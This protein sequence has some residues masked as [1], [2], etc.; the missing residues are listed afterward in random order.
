MDKLQ[1]ISVATG[2]T[3]VEVADA[4]LRILCGCPAD[5]VKHLMKRGLILER[6]KGGVRY[7]SGPNAIL[8][9]DTMLQHGEFSNLAEFPVL[10]M[11]YKQGMLIP[12]HPNNAGQKPLLIGR[13]QQVNAQMQYIFRGNYGL[14]SKEEMIQAGLSE[15]QAEEQMR[16]KLRFA[17]GRISPS[18]QLLD[19]LAVEEQ[20]VEIRAGVFIE[21]LAENQYRI[22]Y[23]DQQIDVDLALPPEQ[24]YETPYPL[25]YQM[26]ER[27]YFAVLHSGEGDGWDV[28][29]PSM[30]SILMYQGRIYLIDAG[31]NL[32]EN[33]SALGIGV[34]EI[35]GIFHTH[36]HDD[37]FSGIT[38][39][40]R[41]GHRLKY[42]AVP[43][44]RST[45]AKK[46]AALLSI[47]EERFGDY[48]E[49]HDLQMGSWNCIEGLEVKP[50]F[51]PHPVET[52]IFEFRALWNDGYK[53]YA[54]FAD[55]VSLDLLGKMVEEDPTKPGVSQALYAQVKEDYLNPVDLKKLDIGGGMIHG[56]AE[57]FR[58]DRSGK[59]FLSHTAQSLTTAQKEIGS[60]APYGVVDV[61]IDSKTDYTRS[62]ARTYIKAY[63]PNVPDFEHETLLNGELLSFNPGSI[64]LKGDAAVDN[65]L[66]L[67]QGNVERLISSQDIHSSMDAGS[68]I[69]EMAVLKEMPAEATYR[70]TN[71]VQALRIPASLFMAMVRR[72]GLL[73]DLYNTLEARSFLHSTTL[74]GE[75]VPFPTLNNLL[76]NM[77]SRRYEPGDYLGCRD[78]SVLNLIESGSVRLMVG[79]EELE[80]LGP[81]AYFGEES[82][83][84]ELPCLYRLEILEPTQVLQ[85]PG[86]LLRKIPIVR[87]KLFEGYHKRSLAVVHG[88]NEDEVFLWRDAFSIQIQ[89]MDI[90]H[91]KLVEI[92]NSI[93]E[94]LRNGQDKGSLLKAFGALVAYTHYHFEAEE[95][96]MSQYHYPDLAEHKLKHKALVEQVLDFQRQLESR[97]DYGEMD[98]KGF[99]SGWLI[100]HILSEDRKY[101]AFLN[102]RCIF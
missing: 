101:G 23:Q 44:V 60:S 93:M 70:A 62:S 72:Y 4:D 47:E 102:D 52:S 28:N 26:F 15:A 89:Q 57:D 46:L 22:S 58:Q 43:H 54:H 49:L 32:Y 90:H 95:V 66:L 13:S 64:I 34:D 87:W 55:I 50:I 41:S 71:F 53:S 40:M 83:V 56:E 85:I 69:G 2:I 14:V 61:L 33:L 45:V 100:K 97:D 88:G 91:Q 37:H 51:S 84:F 36:A 31:P 78:L 35:T 16:M 96:V 48:F 11:L 67:L 99:F 38:T 81:K 21:R 5:S 42:F 59:I 25:G 98:F 27:Q 92:A 82:S 77:V 79:S 9:C 18:H 6:E 80:R 7:E 12:G 86:E 39:L 65:I 17:F 29:R 1:K 68:L 74:F 19:S 75:G 20:R 73:E 3:W 30:S 63:F 10:Q 94:I 24:R 76:D 8:L